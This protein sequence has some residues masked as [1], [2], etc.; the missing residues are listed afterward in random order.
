MKIDGAWGGTK[1]SRDSAYKDMPQHR[2][3]GLV[4]AGGNEVF[5]DGSARWIKFEQMYYLHTWSV[6]GTRISYFY[7][8][9]L[10][11]KIQ[12]N[13]DKIRAKP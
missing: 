13:L 8:D 1:A 4:P 6:D 7:Q 3:A 2:G 5:V 12:S 10:P 9:D 11:D